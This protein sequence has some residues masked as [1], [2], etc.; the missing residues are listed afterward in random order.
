MH[1]FSLRSLKL[2]TQIFLN[3]K[4][5]PERIQ[6]LSLCTTENTVD[7]KPFCIDPTKHTDKEIQQK[8]WDDT[9][10]NAFHRKTWEKIILGDLIEDDSMTDANTNKYEK[11]IFFK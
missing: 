8:I 10:T 2:A 1:F 11:S 9:Q 4:A 5:L 3:L 6:G 7:W